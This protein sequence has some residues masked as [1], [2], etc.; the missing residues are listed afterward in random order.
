M[1]ALASVATIGDI[2]Y[3]LLG[4]FFLFFLW[5]IFWP[6]SRDDDR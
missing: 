6:I 3:G 4:F 1:N 5:M 2:L